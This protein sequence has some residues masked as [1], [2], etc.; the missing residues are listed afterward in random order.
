MVYVAVA[1]LQQ[2]IFICDCP[3]LTKKREKIEKNC[4]QYTKKSVYIG[5]R[6]KTEGELL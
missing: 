2:P 3:F 6:I 4:N 5:E 1:I